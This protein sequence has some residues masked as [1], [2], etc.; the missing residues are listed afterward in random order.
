M[1]SKQILQQLRDDETRILEEF[2]TWIRTVKRAGDV[3]KS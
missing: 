1:T 3:W 2:D